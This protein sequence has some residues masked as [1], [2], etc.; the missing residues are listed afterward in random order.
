MSG[1]IKIIDPIR[2][3]V[4]HLHPNEWNP[5]VQTDETFN[6]LVNEITEDG[7]EQPLN[8]VE[9]PESEWKED[10]V[11][12]GKPHY[13]IIGGEHRWKA[14]RVLGM[15]E[16]PCYVHKDW[17]E[18]QQKLKT[19]RRNLI[20]G[21]LDPKKFTQ[22]VDSL[23]DRVD[24]ELMPHLFGF[25]DDKD[26]QR[27]LLRDKEKRDKSFVDG[28]MDESR[29][30]KRVTDTITDIVA[31]IFASCAETIDQSYLMFEQGGKI[32]MCLLCDKEHWES[33]EKAA[34]HVKGTGEKLTDFFRDAIE[35]KMA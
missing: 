12:D 8:V 11:R 26:M 15:E 2:V 25:E 28:L 35:S 3:A 1:D 5:N 6:Q 19:V 9:V 13:K 18:V 34:K 4:D 32:V 10:W 31:N 22:L 27:F 14:S 23:A 17:D 7:F 20:G 16:L 24:A 29:K 30:E 33:I 21:E